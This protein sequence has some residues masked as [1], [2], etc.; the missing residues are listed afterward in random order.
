MSVEEAD[1]RMMIHAKHASQHCFTKIALA[2]AGT[3]V[4][5]LALSHWPSLHQLG[6]HEM[7]VRTGVGDS[8][9]LLPVHVIH[10]NMGQ[11]LC[12]LL[13][14]IHAL[15]GS[16]YTRKVGTKKAALHIASR[17]YLE[18]YGV[19]HD[20]ED[21]AKSLKSAEE[22]LVQLLRKGSPCKSLDELRLWLYHHGKDTDIEDLLPT[23]RSAK[24][25]L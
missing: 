19:S 12:S 16:D 10:K 4:M 9:R 11:D 6:V 17:T 21:V 24:G 13:P 23:S 25:H 2:S 3:D 22:Y 20:S 7:W 8:T 14:A 15:S 1:F 5:V 18:N